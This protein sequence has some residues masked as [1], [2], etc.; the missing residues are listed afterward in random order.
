[1]T[2]NRGNQGA[3]DRIAA[4]LYHPVTAWLLSIFGL[5]SVIAWIATLASDGHA[6]GI[7]SVFGLDISTGFIFGG[8]GA[9]GGWR[10]KQPIPTVIGSVA[11]LTGVVLT[12][13]AIVRW[14]S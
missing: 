4:I 8:F 10:N 14:V 1:M 11:F 2:Q 7:L 3:M 5:L 6:S 12:V 9:L 13:I